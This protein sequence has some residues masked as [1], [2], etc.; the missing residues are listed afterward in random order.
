[1][2]IIAIA[3]GSGSGKS[4]L[5][6]ALQQD[7]PDQIE[8]L[9]FD[10]YH[11]L[12]GDPTMP[13]FHG[14]VN[15]DHPDIIRWK[16]LINDIRSLQAG[17]EVKIETK[18]KKLN[19]EYNDTGQRVPHIIKPGSFVLVEG[20]LALYNPELNQLYDRKIF[21]ELD[22]VNRNARRDKPA[23]DV[24]KASY[25]QAVLNPMHDKYVEPT[26]KNADLIVD[27]AAKTLDEV[28]NEVIKFLRLG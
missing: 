9:H 7:F 10:D 11:K 28:K 20:Y 26:K 18:S 3:G 22:E 15:W 5:A 23:D 27:V 12:Y 17:S 6:Y 25:V 4:T 21:L 13:M 1:M 2:K 14:N 24:T 8:I 16:E 19:P